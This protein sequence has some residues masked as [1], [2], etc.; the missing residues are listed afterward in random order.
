MA[1]H[2]P[3][4][5]NL[6]DRLIGALSPAAGLARLQA[7]RQFHAYAGA[8]KGADVTRDALAGWQIARG[9]PDELLSRD[10]LTLRRRHA[11]LARNN[12]LAAGAMH[13]K[14]Q[15]VVGTG[16]KY[17]ASIDRDYL[18]LD[19]A[20]ADAWESAAERLFS[21]WAASKDAHLNRNL[22]FYEQ[23]DLSFREVLAGDH[24]IQ[25]VQVQGRELPFRL[26]LNHIAAA[27]V[28]N[29]W[30]Q[31]E[32]ATFIQG[33]EKTPEGTPHTYHVA[34][35]Y[36]DARRPHTYTWAAIPVF[37]SV[38]N[39]RVTLHLY[40][41]LHA[42]QTRG[43]PDL[44]AVMEPLKQ[45]DRYADAELDAAV[46]N[47]MWAL[48][49]ESPTGAGLAGEGN[50][51]DWYAGRE[52]Y[53]DQHPIH[54]RDSGAH[55]IRMFPDDKVSSFD[56]ARPNAA[57]EPFIQAFYTHLGMGLELPKEVLTKAF[58]SSYS[59]ARAALLQAWA[60]FQGRRTWLA[61]NLCD[62]VL[63]AF[64]DEQVAYGRLAAPGYLA[65]PLIRAAY[66]G[67]QW[68]G[69]AR[70]EIDENKAVS[71]AA[72]RIALGISTRKR[73]C[74]ALTGEDYDQ[75]RR[76]LDKEHR[77]GA[78]APQQKGPMP[79]QA[80]QNPDDPAAPPAHGDQP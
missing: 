54:M 55:V 44:A 52:R 9:A 7:R 23:Q 79:A 37:N 42:D 26:A 13:T 35:D 62:P 58:Q 64:I 75:V 47:A 40:R 20:A 80:D 77:M 53:Y 32:T 57:F 16:L 12:P 43:I 69:D 24:F 45:L 48:L 51:L 66:L 73:E 65:D 78:P 50:V 39:R 19:D 68:V 34:D 4:A 28:C 2:P 31:I 6:L 60:F 59:A 10:L 15:G 67:A 25:L 29:P 27:R 70:G 1:E 33:V 61:A 76:Q 22:N 14:T 56:P 63:G 46:K 17:Q 5:A 8:Y 74:A 49:V 72:D 71:A 30:G 18:R 41:Q 38:T 36:P 3:Q 21:T 11:D